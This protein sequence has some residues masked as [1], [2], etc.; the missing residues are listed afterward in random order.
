MSSVR[1]RDV[2][3]IIISFLF[4][5]RTTERRVMKSWRS[6]RTPT[7]GSVSNKSTPFWITTCIPSDGPRTDSQG[8]RVSQSFGR[9]RHS[10]RADFCYGNINMLTFSIISRQLDGASS[11]NPFTWEA[12]NRL[13]I[14]NNIPVPERVTIFKVKHNIWIYRWLSVRLQW[15]QCV[16]N[17][18]T[19]VLH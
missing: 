10:W 17:G 15:L 4:Q 9:N 14:F 5:Q 19:A 16:S 6:Q 13:S 1:S 7:P 2:T 3:E 18:V 12:R 11:W 8:H